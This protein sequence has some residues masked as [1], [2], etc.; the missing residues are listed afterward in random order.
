MSVPSHRRGGGKVQCSK[1]GRKYLKT[2]LRGVGLPLKNPY[3]KVL[4]SFLSIMIPESS[5]QTL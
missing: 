1:N 2:R 3:I 4:A 5:G